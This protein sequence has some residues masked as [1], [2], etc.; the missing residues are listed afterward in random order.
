M[1][2]SAVL[3][4]ED[5]K[6]NLV[7]NGNHR[8]SFGASLI[9]KTKPVKKNPISHSNILSPLQ[10]KSKGHKIGQAVT[11]KIQKDKPLSLHTKASAPPFD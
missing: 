1:Q 10:D 9:Q 6:V 2:R 4:N 7:M 5:I 8:H 3:E 11:V